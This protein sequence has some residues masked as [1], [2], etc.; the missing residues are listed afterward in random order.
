MKHREEADS[1]LLPDPA[2]KFRSQ[3]PRRGHAG[4]IHCCT[5][6]EA[7]CHLTVAYII[8]AGKTTDEHLFSAHQSLLFATYS[9]TSC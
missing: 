2:T 3:L 7:M 6:V 9:V 8:T 5:I 4:G 1:A